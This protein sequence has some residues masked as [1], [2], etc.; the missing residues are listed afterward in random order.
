MSAPSSLNRLEAVT[1]TAANKIAQLEAD[2][3]WYKSALK[4]KSD[5]AQELSNENQKQER[6]IA[7]LALA[8][9]ICLLIG[10]TA[11]ALR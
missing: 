9:F 10:A 6:A 11:L 1:V 3:A 4:E 2:V 7:R 5:W 8:C